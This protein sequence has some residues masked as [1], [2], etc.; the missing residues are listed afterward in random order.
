LIP[1]R[2]SIPEEREPPDLQRGFKR[3]LLAPPCLSNVSGRRAPSVPA[4]MARAL[5]P[6]VVVPNVKFRP[7]A[8]AK[9][10][11]V[12]STSLTRRAGRSLSPF[13][14]TVWVEI[15]TSSELS[16][17]CSNGRAVS[18]DGDHLCWE[19][20][21]TGWVLYRSETEDGELEEAY[22]LCPEGHAPR[23]CMGYRN[24]HPCPRPATVRRG[25]GYYCKEHI[26]V[27]PDGRG[28]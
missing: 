26:I 15:P 2:V 11:W 14:S 3:R 25:S 27:I 18:L 19:C 21:G 9:A 8:Q 20:E 16:R 28:C 24:G 4:A 13:R 5:G 7:G 17:C 10:A 22:R 1:T 23:Y 6:L 12:T